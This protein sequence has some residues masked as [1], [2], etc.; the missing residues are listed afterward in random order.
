M[1]I[2]GD[3]D[4]IVA[5]QIHSE[6]I[7]AAIRGAELVTVHGLGHKPDYIA[8]D[9]VIAAIEKLADEPRDL[10]ALARTVEARLAPVSHEPEPEI[11]FS[12]EKA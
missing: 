3:R 8:T 1:V 4:R 11:D 12:I 7:S 10:Q 6:A 2:T 5:P 9:L